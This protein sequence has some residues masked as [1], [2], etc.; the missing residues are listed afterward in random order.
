VKKGTSKIGMRVRRTEGNINH[1][2]G[3]KKYKGVI[4]SDERYV[5]SSMS[6]Y[7]NVKYDNGVTKQTALNHIEEVDSETA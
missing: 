7:V 2:I 5:A 1:H 4:V 6:Y 3:I